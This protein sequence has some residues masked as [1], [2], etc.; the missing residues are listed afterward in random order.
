MSEKPKRP[1]FRF[2]LLTAVVMM[3]A[4]GGLM[5]ANS[6]MSCEMTELPPKIHAFYH[7]KISIKVDHE[8]AENVFWEYLAQ[9][10]SCGFMIDAQADAPVTLS[11]N[12]VSPA[13][14]LNA[15]TRQSGLAWTAFAESLY[16]STP[17]KVTDARAMTAL[18]EVT[19]PGV[20]EALKK[21][22][23][24]CSPDGLNA[25][26][27]ADFLSSISRLKISS[28]LTNE[29]GFQR[30]PFDFREMKLK[31]V[32]KWLAINY[33]ADLAIEDNTVAFIP[34]C[35]TKPLSKPVTIDQPVAQICRQGWPF[36]FFERVDSDWE[37]DRAANLNRN[38][39]AW[40]VV[41]ACVMVL[42]AG[43]GIEFV[44]RRREGRKP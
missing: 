43:A 24:F 13:E 40:N 26:D 3:V 25:T 12:N 39:F 9:R 18:D 33:S 14:A 11:L 22:V 6:H 27:A 31:N 36:T 42:I 20:R 19:D 41:F 29:Q 16:V 28:R 35:A 21:R 30:F 38:S 5:W 2:H 1:R 37:D 10:S 32:L 44:L 23:S 4:A 17:A 7:G 15:V 34:R 8:P